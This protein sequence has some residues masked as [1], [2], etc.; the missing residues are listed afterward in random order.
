MGFL[1]CFLKCFSSKPQNQVPPQLPTDSIGEEHP[2]SIQ[3]ELEKYLLATRFEK[4][5]HPTIIAQ[6]KLETGNFTS[7]LCKKYNNFS[8]LK[9]REEMEDA[10]G[11][12][13]VSYTSHEGYPIDYC[14]F[15]TRENFVKGYQ[16]FIEREV[17]FDAFS[18]EHQRTGEAYLRWIVECG[19]CPTEGYVEDVLALVDKD[20]PSDPITPDNPASDYRIGIVIGHNSSAQG[21]TNIMGE[22]EFNF[23]SR[24]MEK[25]VSKLNEDYYIK[26]YFRK[27]HVSYSRQCADI[28]SRLDDDAIDRAYCIHFNSYDGKTQGIE[29]LVMSN[30]SSN[31]LK[32][33]SVLAEVLHKGYGYPYRGDKGVKRITNEAGSGMLRAIQG[34]GIDCTLVEHCFGDNPSSKKTFGDEDNFVNLM[35]EGIRK[36]L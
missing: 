13:K 32:M 31:S 21:A 14:A 22:S 1:D 6:W 27:P 8:G 4:Q 16:K 18:P 20:T 2:L 36:A 33:A 34:K 12:R 19:F 15:D 23:H 30:C 35:V 26:M 24:V 9:W 11:C 28:A 3:D 7:E 29:N 5:V 10:E 25:V 17:Y